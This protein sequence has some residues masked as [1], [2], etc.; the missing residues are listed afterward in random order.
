[1]AFA[2]ASSARH[3]LPRWSDTALLGLLAVDHHALPPQQDVQPAIAETAALL[4]QL[5]QLRPKLGIIIPLR[6]VAHALPIGADNTARPPLAWQLASPIFCQK[7]LQTGIVEHRLG[8]EPL[9]LGV[10]ILERP[11]PL[12]LRRL[13]AAILGPPVLDRRFRQAGL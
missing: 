12:R 11:Q 9:Q 2:H 13:Q 8:Q 4:G 10:L 7:I 6:P 3:S 1:M 5:A